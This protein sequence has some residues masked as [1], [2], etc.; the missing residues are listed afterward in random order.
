M[1]DPSKLAQLVKVAADE[2]KFTGPLND[3]KDMTFGDALQHV[4]N[5]RG[6]ILGDMLTHAPKAIVGGGV[7]MGAKALADKLMNKRPTLT[8]EILGRGGIAQKAL[9]LGA[10]G[11]GIGGGAAALSGAVDHVQ[12][13][14]NKNKNFEATLRTNPGLKEF[15]T[16]DLQGAYDALHRF[17]PEIAKEPLAAG[18]FLRRS[19]LFKDEGIQPNDVKTL[20]DVRKLLSES[21]KNENAQST[22]LSAFSAT[23]K[24]LGSLRDK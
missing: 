6:N 9:M 14:V 17:S 7:A 10:V 4:K 23:S 16:E 2:P 11:A 15:K 20:V 8:Q 24:D 22:L 19:M 13:R 12:N 21:R 3:V 5:R 1:I 18:A